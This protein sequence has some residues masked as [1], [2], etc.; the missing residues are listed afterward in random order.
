MHCV[1]EKTWLTP[2]DGA[3]NHRVNQSGRIPE[4]SF[5]LRHELDQALHRRAFVLYSLFFAVV[6]YAADKQWLVRR[7][8]R[9]TKYHSTACKFQRRIIISQSFAFAPE[10]DMKEKNVFPVQ[11]HLARSG[12]TVHMDKCTY[13][14]PQVIDLFISYLVENWCAR[15]TRESCST[16]SNI[17]FI[18]EQLD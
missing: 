1:Q 8:R 17:R 6:R 14:Q 15:Y 5:D 2:V 18:L 16:R 4:D 13:V 10:R 9:S 3:I 12:T 11:S 7:P